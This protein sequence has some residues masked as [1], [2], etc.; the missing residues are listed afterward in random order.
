[1]LSVCVVVGKVI[2]EPEIIK[3]ANGNTM[4]YLY[5]ETA[6]PFRSEDSG[7]NTDVYKVLLWR[8]IAEEC[9]DN[10]DID[11]I[12]AIRG[13]LQSSIYEKDDKSFYNCEIIAEKVSYIS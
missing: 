5:V 1:M 7:P 3:T 12:V 4:A 6:R 10:C 11:S 2:K 9:K 8:G 13:R